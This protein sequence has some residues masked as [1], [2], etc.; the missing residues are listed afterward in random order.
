MSMWQDTSSRGEPAAGTG[1]VFA[2]AG[3][4]DEEWT[5]SWQDPDGRYSSVGGDEQAVTAWIMSRPAERW[6]LLQGP[7]PQERIFWRAPRSWHEVPPDID[8]PPDEDDLTTA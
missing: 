8:D 6:I 5:A 3:R 1:T 4:G 7:H 2:T